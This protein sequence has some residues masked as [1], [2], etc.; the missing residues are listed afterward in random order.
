M[1]SLPAVLFGGLCFLSTHLFAGTIHGKVTDAET[2]EP[3]AGAVV[4]LT[5][6]GHKLNS[7]VQLDGSYQFKNVSTGSYMLNVTDEGYVEVQDMKVQVSENAENV[8]A[9]ISMHNRSTQLASVQVVGAKETTDA[10]A[11]GLEKKAISLQNTLS[12]RTIQLLP[13]VTVANALQRVSGVSIQRS[14]S[15]EGRYAIIRGMDERYNSTLV[16]G[17]KIPSPDA[18]YRYVPMDLFPS[19]MLERLD[20]IKSLTPSMEGDAVGGV[21]NLQMKNAPAHF[22]MS[23]NISGGFSTLFSSDRPFMAF[24][25]GAVNAKSPAEIHG[26]SY[27]ATQT[28]FSRA[29]LNYT[30]KNMPL[31]STAGFTIGDRWM[32]QRL[33]AVLSL[34][35]QNFYRGS[36]SDF[37]VPNAQP[38]VV[39]G[40]DNQYVISD[41]YRRQYSTQTTRFGIHNKIDFILSP[42]SKLALYNMFVQMN[43]YQTRST[44][45]SVYLNKLSDN[46]MRSR[47][48]KQSIYSSTL[49]GDHTI[50]S[51][52]RVNWTG[53][54]AYAK[55][56]VPDMGEYD[57]QSSTTP[58]RYI[59]Q[60]M[61]RI[62]QHNT[63]KDLA[64]YLNFIMTPTISNSKPE[65]SVGG[66]YRHK[67]RDNYYNDYSLSPTLVGGLP[68]YW[69]DFNSAQYQFSPASNGAGDV[70]TTNPNTYT[71]FENVTAGYAQAKFNAG[72][73]LLVVGG[74]RVEHTEQDFTTIMPKSFAGRYGNLNYTDA[75][76]SLNLK[77]A[78]DDRQNLRAS[79][80]RSIVRADF[81]EI[82]PTQIVGELFDIKGN[83]SLKH[84]IAD[85]FDLRYEFFPGGADQFL[86]GAFY[87]II[88]NPIEY[89]VIRNGGPSAQFLMPE[90]FGNAHNFG[91]EA[92]YTKY[93]GNFGVSANYTYTK[94]QITTTKQYFYRDSVLGITSKIVSQTRPMQGQADHIGNVSLLYK[95]PKIGLDVQLAFVYTGERIS[96]VSPY[97][98]LDYYQ[99]GQGILDF[100]FEKTIVHRLSVY[101]KVNNL[102]NTPAK[103]VILQAPDVN[104]KFPDQQYSSKT[105]VGKDI[106]GLNILIGVRFKV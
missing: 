22:L 49:Q 55:S 27:T 63:D 80:F 90:N 4:T 43:E 72:S 38:Q 83:D 84:S 104:S 85:N 42:K 53:V 6:E 103:T 23:A 93:F 91:I 51:V 37:L 68:Q 82:I 44:Y 41:L 59:V 7:L 70:T 24:D 105:V 102:T 88:K 79:Y 50:N 73:N 15:G 39:N 19:E 5:S 3:L 101:G 45:D 13:D 56:Q 48:Q 52:F 9:N 11:R 8:S 76:P 60:K 75:L 47:M 10:G 81:Y 16:N 58:G 1:R 92:V 12:E 64:G 40:K 17:I 71:S 100:S 99:L 54:Y 57:Y 98:N 106:Y 2:G 33:G 67:T 94:S 96:Q 89:A 32:H 66:M 26:N 28:D 14:T 25:H 36:N 69:T 61:S 87:K 46:L 35:F 20:V 77:Y 78:L 97:Y 30:S 18:K 62:W 74:L 34:S 65:I 31:N 86:V 95:N 21:M 29:N